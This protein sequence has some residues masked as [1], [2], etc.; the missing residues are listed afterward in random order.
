MDNFFSSSYL[1]DDLH[2]RDINCYEIVG[3]TRGIN[4]YGIVGQNHKGMPGDFDSN[5]LKLKWNVLCARGGGVSFWKR[6]FL[7][8]K[9]NIMQF[10][11]IFSFTYLLLE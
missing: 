7:I 9:N 5:T 4:C 3:Q 10:G 2:T 6:A 8:V 11:N 1:F